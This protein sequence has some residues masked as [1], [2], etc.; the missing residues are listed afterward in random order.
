MPIKAVVFDLDGTIVAFNIDYKALRAEVR[1]YLVKNGVPD[2][3]LSVKESIFEMLKKADLAFTNAG[4][5]AAF[6]NQVRQEASLMLPPSPE[7]DSS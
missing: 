4:K 5:S 3:L 6:I 7:F 1:G 2:S